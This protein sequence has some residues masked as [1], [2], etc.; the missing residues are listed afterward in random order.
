MVFRHVWTRHENHG[1]SDEA[2]FRDA[3]RSSTADDEVGSLV[4][5]THISDEIGDFQVFRLFFLP[6]FRRNLFAVVFSR[7]PN[8]LHIVALLHEVQMTQDAL[9]NRPCTQTSA[10]EQNRLL[11]RVE[12]EG[13]HGLVAANGRFQQCLTNGISRQHQA[14]GREKSLHTLVGN[15]DFLG[16][17]A[18]NHIRFSGKGIL[19]L[20]QVGNTHTASRLQRRKTGV[21]THTDSHVGLKFADDFAH[22]SVAL[23]HFV[24]QRDVFQQIRTVETANRQSFD[25]VARRR[26]ALHFHPSLGTDKQNFRLR[27]LFPD[28]IGNRD[29][30][31]NVAAR[32]ASA[33]DDSQFLLH[34]SLT[35]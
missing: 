20:N 14:V 34:N 5:D 9:V 4:S 1:F 27:L 19:F 32:S 8:E 16:F 23:P 31:K 12:T 33:D 29:G 6:H 18:Q 2:E 25:V 15:A 10:N 11:R 26:Y 30:R 17:L 22:H 13:S 35:P 21:S 7:L 28:G 3:T 24:G